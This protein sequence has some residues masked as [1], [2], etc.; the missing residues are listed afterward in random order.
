MVSAVVPPEELEETAERVAADLVAGAPLAQRFIKS[1]LA[2]ATTMTFEQALAWEA[3]TQAV[4][5]GSTDVG[6]GAAA[7]LDKREPR[8]EGR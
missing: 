2:R 3:Q 6:E 7:F 5:L 8:F 4:L 1:G